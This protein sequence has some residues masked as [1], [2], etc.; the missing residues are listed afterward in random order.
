MFQNNKL[1]KNQWNLKKLKLKYN[2]FNNNNYNNNR[3]NKYNKINN[4][5]IN[6]V[7]QKMIYK[8]WHFFWKNLIILYKKIN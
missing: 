5:K 6:K 8:I 7:I 2:K 3:Y 4:N 1:F